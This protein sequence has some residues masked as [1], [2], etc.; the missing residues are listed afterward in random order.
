MCLTMEGISMSALRFWLPAL[1]A[2]GL[3]QSTAAQAT[4]AQGSIIV[5]GQRLHSRIDDFVRRLT[6][7]RQDQLQR[8]VQDV[9]PAVV[10]LS[11]ELANDVVGRIR[12]VAHAVGAPV[13]KARCSPNIVL[14]VVHDKQTAIQQ[15]RAG[16][17]GVFGDMRASDLRQ[18][19]ENAG[20]TAAWQV[21]NRLGADGMPL[22]MVRLNPTDGTNDAVPMVRGAF[23]SRTSMQIMRTVDLSLLVVEAPALD[24]VDTRQLADYTAMRTL[25]PASAPENLPARSILQLFNAG[26]SPLEAPESVT[27]WDFAFLKS[28]YRSSNKVEASAQRSQIRRMMMREL[29][30]LPVTE[31]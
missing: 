22:T 6:P 27:W 31:R 4:A 20:P 18:L 30:K 28:L 16:L 14:L 11:R 8:F 2:L 5:E 1:A 3:A 25:A 9:C 29:D 26:M 10:G 13:A 24:Q 21:S 15:L 17:P 7:A 23:L 19:V 12:R